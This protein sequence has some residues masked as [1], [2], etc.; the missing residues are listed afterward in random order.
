MA[1]SRRTTRSALPL[2]RLQR[3]E[4]IGGPASGKTT[5]ARQLAE[6]LGAPVYHLDE[7]AFEGGGGTPRS[8]AA[9]LAGV[10]AIL[11]QPAWVAEGTF[12]G[13]T[14]RL[15]REAS[16]IVWLDL[17]WQRAAWRFTLRHLRGDW[18]GTAALRP[19][20]RATSLR[21]L[22]GFLH[23]IRR[24]ARAPSAASPEL[25]EFY[26][27]RAATVEHLAPFATKLLHLRRPAEVEAFLER[28]NGQIRARSFPH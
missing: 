6:R 23:Y 16:L 27:S 8:L 7:V 12:I 24:Y 21:K 3:I 22:F 14:D 26:P 28:L 13:W 11:A 5:L 10:N 19:L 20:R 2:D 25:S 9:R 15:L 17:P 18:S 4:I 1:G